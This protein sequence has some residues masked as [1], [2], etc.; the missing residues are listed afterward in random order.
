MCSVIWGKTNSLRLNPNAVNVF[1]SPHPLCLGKLYYVSLNLGRSSNRD[2]VSCVF[3]I[4]SGQERTA[5]LVV[6]ILCLLLQ[7][8]VCRVR[9][10]RSYPNFLRSVLGLVNR[11]QKDAHFTSVVVNVTSRGP[12][13]VLPR[14]L[15]RR[16]RRRYDRVGRGVSRTPPSIARVSGKL[17]FTRTPC[18]DLL[19]W[20]QTCLEDPL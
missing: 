20:I 10:L 17:M 7:C 5:N 14:P 9:E 8:L 3:S 4:Y 13:W 12:S 19:T 18:R 16:V 2:S 6:K 15:S 11:S 1:L